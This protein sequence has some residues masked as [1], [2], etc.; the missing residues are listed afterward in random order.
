MYRQSRQEAV[1]RCGGTSSYHANM[2]QMS[3]TYYANLCG[4]LQLLRLQLRLAFRYIGL[5]EISLIY[6]ENVI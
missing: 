1:G 3:L 6:Y 5:K 4:M 2:L